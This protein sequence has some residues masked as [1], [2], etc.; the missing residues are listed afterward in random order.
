[1]SFSTMSEYTPKIT[2][3]PSECSRRP[4]LLWLMRKPRQLSAMCCA[5]WLVAFWP[6]TIL[7]IY[8]FYVLRST[9]AQ[10]SARNPLFVYFPLWYL[11]K[12]RIDETF[13]K[14]AALGI[15]RE[16]WCFNRDTG[17][18]DGKLGDSR[19]NRESWQVRLAC[20]LAKIWHFSQSTSILDLARFENWARFK[21]C[22]YWCR[23]WLC[24]LLYCCFPFK[25]PLLDWFVIGAV[26][27]VD[28]DRP[29][30]LATITTQDQLKSFEYSG[31][32]KH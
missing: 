26:M 25:T 2:R 18:F 9:T 20:L 28:P 32:L 23:Q 17:R 16:I 29:A 1:M 30:D 13:F 14:K 3:R 15:S 22:T 31:K 24:L 11:E 21:W 8:Q 10:V 12:N 4:S 27:M 5:I 19:E 6:T 7:I